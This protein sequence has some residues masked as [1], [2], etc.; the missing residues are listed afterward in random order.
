MY[1]IIGTNLFPP[2][3]LL[4]KQGVIP[5]HIIGLIDEVHTEL[6]RH[7]ITLVGGPGF[8]YMPS[9]P[10]N[11]PLTPQPR[12]HYQQPGMCTCVCVCTCVRVYRREC[13][14]VRVYVRVCV[15]VCLSQW[16]CMHCSACF[17]ICIQLSVVVY[18]PFILPVYSP[19]YHTTHAHTYTH[20]CA[21]THMGTHTCSCA[22]THMGTH[23]H[24]C[25]HT[26]MGT[27]THACAHTHMGTHT[28]SCAHTHMGTHTHACAHTHMGT[29][30]HACA[31]THMGTHTCSCAHAVHS[32]RQASPA[33]P[34]K[35]WYGGDH[36]YSGPAHNLHYS[37]PSNRPVSRKVE[38]SLMVASPLGQ[39]EQ[40]TSSGCLHTNNVCVYTGKHTY[41]YKCTLHTLHT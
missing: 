17:M 4:Q 1:C 37:E 30:T 23:T 8:P 21:H 3:P 10:V 41:V 22:H 27:H 33:L 34:S 29:H 31:H 13:T 20:A 18:I 40:Q 15:C 35:R 25:A 7:N 12:R 32:V 19:S 5:P 26:H 6:V 2:F 36:A 11:P 38:G 14:C 39:E 28:C 16:V 9:Y 24:A